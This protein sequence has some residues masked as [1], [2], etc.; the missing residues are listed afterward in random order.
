MKPTLLILAAGMGSR[1]GGLKQLDGI[2]P[3]GE[4]IMDYSVYDALRAGFGKVV[5]VIRESFE[6]EFRE[7]VISKYEDHIQVE[8]VFQDLSDLPD[9]FTLNP[10]REKPWGTSHALL[11]AKN[12][13]NEPFASINADD[14]YGKESYQILAGQLKA[15]EGKTKEYCMVGYMVG[16]TLSE[17]GS[18][19]RGVCQVNSESYLKQIVERGKIERI[20]GVPRFMDDDKQWKNLTDTTYVSMNM[21]GF[22]PYFF[23]ITESDFVEFLK[24]NQNHPKAEFLIPTHVDSLVKKEEVKV[25]LLNTPSKWFGITYAEDR[26][27]VVHKIQELVDNGKYPEKLFSKI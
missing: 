12:V 3:N 9:G 14:F 16:N 4:T 15:M 18:V 24:E 2:G 19:T 26:P 25:K 27:D 20:D 5:F 11:M 7:K 1:Y 13:I 8:V 22:T 17:S 6:K 23:D 21:W 10:E